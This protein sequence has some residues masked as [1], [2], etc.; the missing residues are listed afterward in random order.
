MFRKMRAALLYLALLCGANTALADG[1]EAYLTGEMRG[2]VLHAA[3]VAVPDLPF[4]KADDSEGA[5]SEY[6]G[7]FVLLNFWATWCAPCRHEMPALNMLQARLGGADFQVVTLATGRNPPQAIRRFFEE[8]N[9]TVLTRHRDIDQRIAREMGVFGLP[10]SVILDREGRE[11]GRLRGDA[12]WAS[13]EAFALIEAII[14]A[15]EG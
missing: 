5:L 2:V 8:E 13:P 3:P 11:I 9:L 10:I 15:P 12:D 14:G 6:R 1:L 7:R 4:L